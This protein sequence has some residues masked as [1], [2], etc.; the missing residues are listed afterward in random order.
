MQVK[1]GIV[2]LLKNFKIHPCSK[3]LIPMKFTPNF[4]FQAPHGGMWLKIEPLI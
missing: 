2:K 4:G 3:T 1:I